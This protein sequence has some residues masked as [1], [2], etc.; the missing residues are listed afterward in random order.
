MT[1]PATTISRQIIV[2]L[3]SFFLAPFGLWFAWKYLKQDDSKSQKIGIVAIAL[4]VISGAVTIWTMA[5]LFNSVSQFMK[6]LNGLG[7]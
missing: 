5:G 7:L 4:T 6:S 2:Y 3:I 1:P